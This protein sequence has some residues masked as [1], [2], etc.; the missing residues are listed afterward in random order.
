MEEVST[1]V[2]LDVHKD[3]IDVTVAEQ[4]ATGEVRHFGTICGD[5]EAV[6][7]LVRRLRR[8]GRTL[9][10]VYEAGRYRPGR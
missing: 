8:K 9:H 4:G 5:L 1:Y 10:F 3:P 2:G 7:K 6:A